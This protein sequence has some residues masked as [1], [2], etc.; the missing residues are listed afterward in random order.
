M[1][2]SG[3]LG[4]LVMLGLIWTALGAVVLV[5]LLIRDWKHGELW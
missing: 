5:L 2:S 3:F 1:F 4:F